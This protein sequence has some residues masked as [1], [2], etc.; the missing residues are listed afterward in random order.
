MCSTDRVDANCQ[1][2]LKQTPESLNYRMLIIGQIKI[3]SPPRG[4][5]SQPSDRVIPRTHFTRA[6][7]SLTL[8]PI[9]LGGRYYISSVNLYYQNAQ[10]R[11]PLWR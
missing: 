2:R 8:Y 9:E 11:P 5:N 6:L 7:K 1:L 4:S 10:F 3:A